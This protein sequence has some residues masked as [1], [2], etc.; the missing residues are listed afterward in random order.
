MQYPDFHINQSI[1]Q[2]TGMSLNLFF[3]SP[4]LYRSHFK[5][6]NKSG[7]KCVGR[8]PSSYSQLAWHFNAC[9]FFDASEYRQ[10]VPLA[11]HTLN[12]MQCGLNVGKFTSVPSSWVTLMFFFSLCHRHLSHTHHTHLFR[13]TNDWISRCINNRWWWLLLLLHLL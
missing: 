8:Q 9:G 13:Y 6:E 10:Q 5:Y 3:F 11:S 2:C 12:R 7:K 4:F 1:N